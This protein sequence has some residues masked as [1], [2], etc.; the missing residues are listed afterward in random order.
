MNTFILCAKIPS[1]INN[2]LIN[3]IDNYNTEVLLYLLLIVS[4]LLDTTPADNVNVI[5]E[6]E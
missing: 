3:K 2:E 4:T 1:E 6:R 5:S